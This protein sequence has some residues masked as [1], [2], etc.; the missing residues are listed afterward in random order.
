MLRFFNCHS[1]RCCHFVTSKFVQ[2]FQKVFKI[3]F[4]TSLTCLFNMY[5]SFTI[6]L[7]TSHFL[8]Y[9]LKLCLGQFCSQTKHTHTKFR[10]WTFK[11]QTIQFLFFLV[12]NSISPGWVRDWILFNPNATPPVIVNEP[13]HKRIQLSLFKSL[14]LLTVKLHGIHSIQKPRQNI[15]HPTWIDSLEKRGK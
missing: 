6:L 1:R 10:L 11:L 15:R 14:L 13:H 7:F 12:L 2:C 3:L 4:Q 8:F 5:D 9:G